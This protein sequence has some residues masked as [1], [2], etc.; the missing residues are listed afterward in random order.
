MRIL[1][2]ADG[3]NGVVYHR[4]YTPLV[5]LQL[6]GHAVVD[7]AQDSD[8]MLNR[9]NYKDYDLIVFNRWLGVHHYD[10]LTKIAKAKTPFV[11]DVD[12]Y[13][14][15]PK[16]NPAYW[17]YRKGIKNAIKDALAYADGVTCT[18]SQLLKEVKAYNKN[19]IVIPNCIDYEHEQWRHSRLDNEKFKVGW[20]GGIT[21]HEDLKLIVDAITRLGEEGKIEFYLCGY[22]PSDIWD[23]ICSMFKGDWFHIVRGTNA[24]AYG[25]VYKHFDLVVAPLQT[26]KFNSC[27]SELKILEASAYDL[28]IVV[29]ACEPYTNHIDNA[30]VIF[31]KN[32]EWYESITQAMQNTT[33]L[34][35][36]NIY[37][38]KKFHDISM[39]NKKRISFYQSLCK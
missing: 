10:I 7:I 27:K 13:W 5:R 36:S 22:T 20:V 15:L 12:D 29:S 32:D 19:A 16:Y 33:H 30:G 14:V 3:M 6:D 26:T 11:V 39:W 35:Y 17:A 8:T 37:Y 38:C 2:L 34:G 25:E 18:T 1:A 28:P 21:H 4:I 24:N 23:S 31:A 9:V